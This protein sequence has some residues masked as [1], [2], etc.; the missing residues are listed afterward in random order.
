MNHCMIFRPYSDRDHCAQT[1]EDLYKDMESRFGKFTFDPCP[2]NPDFDG[3]KCDWSGNVY[4]NP[5]FK[6]IKPWLNKAKHEWSNEKC[7]SVT[8][9]MPV[10]TETRYFWECMGELLD[11]GKV[12]VFFIPKKLKF[13]GYP[14]PLGIPLMVLHFP[15][16]SR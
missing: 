4:V 15:R 10:R 3:L 2:P 6:N 11:L 1:P 12:Q 14:R 8:I 7:E 16:K 13:K 9:L 5:P